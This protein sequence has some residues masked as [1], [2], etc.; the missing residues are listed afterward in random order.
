MFGW[1]RQMNG[2]IAEKREEELSLIWR[3]KLLDLISNMV[4]CVNSWFCV[5]RLDLF[6][7]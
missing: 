1:E 7:S 2:R 4:K 5:I 3:R 6:F